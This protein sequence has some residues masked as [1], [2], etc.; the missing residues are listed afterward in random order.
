MHLCD[1]YQ[2]ELLDQNTQLNENPLMVGI[3]HYLHLQNGDFIF[4]CF[5][6][7]LFKQFHITHLAYKVTECSPNYLQ[8]SII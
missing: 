6:I 1:T 4:E 5:S 3:A 7:F 2:V 8:G